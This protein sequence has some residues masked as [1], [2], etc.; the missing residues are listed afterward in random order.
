MDL[1]L[2][3]MHAPTQTSIS[4]DRNAS[5]AVE[6]SFTL[7]ISACKELA[8]KLLGHLPCSKLGATPGPLPSS[9][10]RWGRRPGRDWFVAR[11]PQPQ[12]V[13]V[14]SSECFSWKYLRCRPIWHGSHSSI[15]PFLQFSKT[16]WW[17]HLVC[18]ASFFLKREDNGSYSLMETAQGICAIC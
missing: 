8:R 6:A 4:W 14:W 1:T 7:E 5:S 9:R 15:E 11:A 13:A 18:K 16:P 2:P 12:V 10:R 3:K 17:F